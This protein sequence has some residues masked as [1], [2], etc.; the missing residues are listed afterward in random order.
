MG[1]KVTKEEND[2]KLRD[3]DIQAVIVAVEQRQ[4]L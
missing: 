4:S 1:N 2:S 3:L